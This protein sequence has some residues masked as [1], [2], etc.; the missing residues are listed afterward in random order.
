MTFRDLV[1]VSLTPDEKKLVKIIANQIGSGDV[2]AHKKD[3]DLI[4]DVEGGF[5]PGIKKDLER[6]KGLIGKN[7]IKSEIEIDKAEVNGT[8]LTITFKK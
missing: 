8:S 7:E 3:D 2:D 1:E 4:I 6:I 5:P